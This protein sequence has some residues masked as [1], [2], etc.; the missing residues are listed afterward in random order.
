MKLFVRFGS[1]QGHNL[2]LALGGGMLDTKIEAAPAQGIA[3]S[4][5]FIG[6][7]NNE[8]NGLCFDRTQ[9]G[10]AQPPHAQQLQQD[11]LELV[12]N[13]VKFINEQDTS[14][15]ALQ[16]PQ[17]WPGPKEPLAMKLCSQCLPIQVV[18]HL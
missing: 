18:A 3:D 4:A 14:A 16:C 1:P 2:G 10:N 15:A 17:Q 7:Q 6:S 5:L 9:F 12:V 13:L 11:G 8:G